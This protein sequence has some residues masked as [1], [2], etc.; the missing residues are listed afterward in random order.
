MIQAMR[1]EIDKI[2]IGAQGQFINLE[3][4]ALTQEI[5]NA[6]Q[7][8]KQG[9]QYCPPKSVSSAF[10]RYTGAIMMGKTLLNTLVCLSPA[11][12]NGME[13]LNSLRW[14]DGMSKLRAPNIREKGVNIETARVAAV[15]LA[16]KTAKEFEAA[17]QNRFWLGRKS[18]AE[19][20]ALILRL[21]EQ[22]RYTGGAYTPDRAHFV[23]L[24]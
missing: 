14:G 13:N 7:R 20:A 22:L 21:W 12:Q 9:T 24:I 18:R 3:L 19:H 16:A 23:L 4:G 6:T 5:I 1:G 2:P 17:P 11:P 8:Y 10:Q 15:K